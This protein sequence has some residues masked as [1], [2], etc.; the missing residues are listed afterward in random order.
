M[1]A[2]ETA[3]GASKDRVF[4]RSLEENI[5]IAR[6]SDCDGKKAEALA[7]ANPKVD[8]L[9]KMK[10]LLFR[11]SIAEAETFAKTMQAT[12]T[13]EFC[14][15]TLEFAR[16]H[17]FKGEWL[18]SKDLCDS[19]LFQ[20]HPAAITH[21]TALSVRA[22]AHFELGNYRQAHLDLQ[23]VDSLGK[24]F[25]NAI[26]LIY[27]RVLECK[28]L[29]RTQSAQSAKVRLLELWADLIK[30]N[31]LNLDVVSALIRT[32]IDLRR[33]SGETYKEL[34]IA[35]Y[36]VANQMGEDLY[37]DLAILDIFYASREPNMELKSA[38]QASCRRQPR[39]MKL[40]EEIDTGASASTTARA[41]RSQIDSCMNSDIEPNPFE[42]LASIVFLN[43]KIS[44][45]LS[46][47]K[48]Y[49][50]TKK[51]QILL[52]LK[53]LKNAPLSKP[54]LFSSL[55][56]SQKYAPYLHDDLIRAL[57]KRLRKLAGLHV[58]L[59]RGKIFLAKTLVVG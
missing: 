26:T 5:F 9:E 24:V 25:P 3:F 7:L 54:E 32:E 2:F 27:A 6:H 56:G 43:H 40:H 45:N 38:F 42:Q 17:A 22:V 55:W 34:A 53:A 52:A 29:A 20:Y 13:D 36:L 1:L 47:F 48:I 14:E 11:G 4:A 51:E 30:S 18:K 57:V 46:P 37:A 33:L 35:C 16:L 8:S 39:L 28:I 19:I 31:R 58:D 23:K 50:L 59:T 21:M 41:I 10:S 49:D 15:L 44:I 12:T